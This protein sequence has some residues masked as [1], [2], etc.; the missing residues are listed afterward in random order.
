MRTSAEEL[1]ACEAFGWSRAECEAEI[2]SRMVAGQLC[3]GVVVHEATGRRCIPREVVERTQAARAAS[4]LA[5]PT[6]I[7]AGAPSFENGRTRQVIA[8]AIGAAVL[9]GLYRLT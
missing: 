9:Y 2:A 5:K 6:A 1:A 4:P 8:F 3:D 7:V